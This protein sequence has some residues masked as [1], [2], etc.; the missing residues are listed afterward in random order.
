MNRNII[1]SFD[2]VRKTDSTIEVVFQTEEKY[3]VILGG[4]YFVNDENFQLEI[5]SKFEYEGKHMVNGSVQITGWNEPILLPIRDV[6]L[7]LA[8]VKFIEDLDDPII[9]LGK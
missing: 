4:V 3:S 9:E 7:K 1:V 5:V 2:Y 8:F 6:E